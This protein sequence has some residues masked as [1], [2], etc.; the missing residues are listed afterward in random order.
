SPFD[1]I[2]DN[3]V[4]NEGEYAPS[5]TPAARVVNMSRIKIQAE[6]PEIYS[7]T[8]QVGT[9]AIVTFDAL[10]GDTMKGRVTFASSTVSAANRTMTIEIVLSNNFKRLKTDMVAKVTLLRETKLKALLI[11][12]NIIQLVDRERTIVYVEKDGKAEERRLKLGGRQGNMVEVLEGLN[13]GDNL[14]ISGYQK[15]VNGT[16]VVI[17]Q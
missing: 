8:I 5:G 7:G 17:V 11:S 3:I 15:L 10:P 4:P 2:V 1:G 13:Q 6:I 12:E 9:Q 14:I 16:P